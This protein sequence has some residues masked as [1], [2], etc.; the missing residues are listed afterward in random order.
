MSPRITLNRL[1]RRPVARSGADWEA[2][3]AVKNQALAL[4]P[5]RNPLRLIIEPI[6][7]SGVVARAGETLVARPATSRCSAAIEA[8]DQ[9][10]GASSMRSL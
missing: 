10:L 3:I 8:P 5:Y 2:A 9:R 6:S 4:Q 7:A 1:K